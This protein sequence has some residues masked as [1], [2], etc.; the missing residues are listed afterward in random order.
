MREIRTARGRIL[1]MQ[2]LYD[3]NPTTRAVS[4]VNVNAKGDLL[5]EHGNVKIDK[6]IITAA[7]YEG[8]PKATK[9]VSIKKSTDRDPKKKIQPKVK[10]EEPVV[11]MDSATQSIPKNP[12]I[13]SENIKT[14]EDGSSY[15]EVEYNDGSMEIIEITGNET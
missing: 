13:V 12:S 3:A 5:D 1:N 4:N 9:T 6:E 14:R 10:K 7:Y 8:D 15:K 11:T 2:A